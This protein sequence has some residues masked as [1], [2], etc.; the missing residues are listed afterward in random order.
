MATKPRGR[1]SSMLRVVPALSVRY[2][3]LMCE[4]FEHR[5]YAQEQADELLAAQSFEIAAFHAE[6]FDAGKALRLNVRAVSDYGSYG[7]SL[8]GNFRPGPNE[9][10]IHVC[11]IAFH[12]YF[13]AIRILERLEEKTF[14]GREM[15]LIQAA[16]SA[17]NISRAAN[18]SVKSKQAETAID[19]WEKALLKIENGRKFRNAVT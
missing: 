13:S 9:H 16:K 11:D 8:L 4:R 7:D 19:N 17:I 18:D 6:S 3:R 12:S 14:M 1:I 2:S 10:T 5:G 15:C